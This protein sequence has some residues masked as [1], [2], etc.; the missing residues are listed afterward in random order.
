MKQNASY[1]N[2]PSHPALH[3]GGDKPALVQSLFNQLAPHYDKLNDVISLGLHRHWKRQACQSLQ[4]VAGHT[5]LDVCTGTGDLAAILAKLVG[6]R[7]QVLA[8]DFSPAM[9]AVARQRWASAYPQVVFT[10]GDALALPY[11]DNLANGAVMSFGLRNVADTQ[12]ALNELCRVVRRGGRVAILDTCP[13]PNLPGFKWY[14]KHLMPKLGQALSGQGDAYHY[15][16][17]STEAFIPPQQL[18]QQLELAG[19]TKVEVRTLA[20]GAAMLVV[21]QVR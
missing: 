10:Q 15:L 19:A 9:L 1:P 21:G 16:N 20:M 13:T 7:G 12:T 2:S 4:L 18:A 3:E 6:E 17:Q 5:A 8:L 11:A 14:F